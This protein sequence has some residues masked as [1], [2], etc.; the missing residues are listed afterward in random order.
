MLQPSAAMLDRFSTWIFRHP[1]LVVLILAGIVA[2]I[3]G[4]WIW[5]HRLQGAL[6]PDESGYIATAFRYQRTLGNDPL[7]LPREIGGTGNGP[8]IPL[9]SV[10]LLW[11]GP[12]DPRTALLIQP[13]LGLVTAVASA[14]IA[15]KLAVQFN[16]IVG[17]SPRAQLTEG[18]ARSSTKHSD[19]LVLGDLGLGAR[20]SNPAPFQLAEPAYF[21]KTGLIQKGPNRV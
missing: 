6:D 20:K 13:I 8:L 21:A 2:V 16:G 3:Q 9:L 14:G 17:V 1:L 7:A 11:I 19:G 18:E 10:P 4:V 5:N 12:Q 15:R